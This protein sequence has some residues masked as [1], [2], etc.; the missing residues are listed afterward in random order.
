M[1][2]SLPPRNNELSGL[3]SAEALAALTVPEGSR[4]LDIGCGNGSTAR[5]LAGR[6]CRVVGVELN[7]DAA[8]SARDYCERV[9]VGDIE[10]P[11]T[12]RQLADETFDAIVL[13]DVLG[14][15]R[16]PLSVLGVA[17]QLLAPAG[18]IVTSFANITHGAVRLGLLRGDFVYTESG[19]LDRRRLRLFDRQSAEALMVEAGLGIEERLHVTRGLEETEIPTDTTSY[20]AEIVAALRRDRDATTYEIVFVAS[21][22]GT[23]GRST[24]VSLAEQL[25]RQ[26]LDLQAKC[27]ALEARFRRRSHRG[28]RTG[29]DD[30]GFGS[31]DRASVFARR[32][33]GDGADQPDRGAARPPP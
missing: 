22:S 28:R 10:A 4:V 33:A 26:V 30:P 24:A 31:A 13:L 27:R 11:A 15:L 18:R 17:R 3:N 6:G 5:L 16:D 20:P 19:L 21:G 14:Y 7:E 8:R 1:E 23:H 2:T 12:Q 32:R 25:Q 29:G 9:I